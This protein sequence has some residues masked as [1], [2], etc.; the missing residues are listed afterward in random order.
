MATS[1]FSINADTIARRYAPL[2]DER[3]ASSAMGSDDRQLV[4]ILSSDFLAILLPL[5]IL[6]LQSE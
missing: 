3:L 6:K 5:Q 4:A 2:L 1:Q